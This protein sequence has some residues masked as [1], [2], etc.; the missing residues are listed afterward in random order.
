MVGR[1]DEDRLSGRDGDGCHDGHVAGKGRAGARGVAAV[2]VGFATLCGA[3]GDGRGL[4][5]SGGQRGYG[6]A[7]K[8]QKQTYES[9]EAN[10]ADDAG[11]SNRSEEKKPCDQGQQGREDE[12]AVAHDVVKK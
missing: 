7:E 12:E 4:H 2:R 1:E 10:L 3:F 8:Q 5:G 9:H 6:H 11:E